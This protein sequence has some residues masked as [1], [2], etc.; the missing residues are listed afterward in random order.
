MPYKRTP[1]SS[2]MGEFVL[3]RSDP[4]GAASDVDLDSLRVYVLN[5]YLKWS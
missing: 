4:G 3:N 1:P 5:F 2:E